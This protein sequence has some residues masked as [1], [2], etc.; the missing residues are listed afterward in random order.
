VA[1]SRVLPA[2]LLSAAVAL[3]ACDGADGTAT[4]P[5]AVVPVRVATVHLTPMQ[6]TARYAA[7][8]RPRFETAM[9]FRV[10]G[11]IA[12]RLVD[13]GARVTAGTI[14]ARLDPADLQLAVRAGEAQLG[15]ARAAAATAKAD[16]QRYASLRQGDW[17][18]RQEY[19]RRKLALDT[20]EAR[21]REVEADIKVTRNNAQYTQLTADTDGVVTAVLAEAGQVVAQGQPVLRI[22]RQGEIEAV[23][24]I[25]EQR[26][27]D[28]ADASLTV[29]LWSM[30]GVRVPGR[31]RELAPAADADTRTYQARV[32][33]VDPPA[34]VQWGMTATLVAARRD[35]LQV[36]LLPLTA[37]TKADGKPAVWGLNAAADGLRLL[38]VEVRSYQGEQVVIGSGLSEG[39]RVVTAGV[40]M[41]DP[42][43]K[44]RVWTEP[45]R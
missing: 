36:A 14:L 35:G 19:D 31:L 4:A 22:A 44:I 37:L 7:V 43:M 16:F 25:P 45:D 27:T 21:V 17:T 5:R 28:F 1:R 39:E 42:T 29:E 23:A 26:L 24:A 15:S 32:T 3:A 8:I 10:G 38:P 40:F 20:A 11:K 30:A 2:V 13:A 9:A 6:D 12:E 33:L 34:A 41:L 18:T